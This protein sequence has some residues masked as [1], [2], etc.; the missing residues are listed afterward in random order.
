MSCTRVRSWERNLILNY[1]GE[2]SSKLKLPGGG[3]QGTILGLF[4][5][6]ILINSL[7]QPHPPTATSY[8]FL[9]NSS[10]GALATEMRL[11]LPNSCWQYHRNTKQHTQT[12]KKHEK[13]NHLLKQH[14]RQL[15]HH[16]VWFLEKRKRGFN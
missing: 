2:T 14:H 5:F 1:K 7:S 6:L 13:S 9:Y 11:A 16:Q 3:P 10:Q 15:P 8:Q 12:S 4:L